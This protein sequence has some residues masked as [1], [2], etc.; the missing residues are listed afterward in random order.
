MNTPY[1][2]DEAVLAELIATGNLLDGVKLHLA[3]A[4]PA[5]GP[6]DVVADFTEAA[7]TGY[8][9]VAVTWGGPY[10]GPD[11]NPEVNS[12][13]CR[14]ISSGTITESITHW[15]LTDS[16]G[17][18]LLAGDAL[19]TPVAIDRSGAGLSLILQ[20]RRYDGSVRVI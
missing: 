18:V 15:F 11:G 12:Q 8:A 20:Y 7:F 5:G 19:D 17:T 16:A 6:Y 14:F 3:T 4:G 10:L 9:A 2:A 13:L 1:S